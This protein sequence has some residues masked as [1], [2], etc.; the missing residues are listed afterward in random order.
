MKKPSSVIKFVFVNN[1]LDE[2][3]TSEQL[4]EFTMEVN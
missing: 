3:V 2:R 1:I 4:A